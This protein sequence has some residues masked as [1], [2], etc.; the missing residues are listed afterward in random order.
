M[1]VAIRAV[2]PRVHIPGGAPSERGFDVRALATFFGLACAFSWAW[3]FPLVLSGDVVRQGRGWP[4]HFPSLVGPALAAFVVVAWTRG[5]PG[6]HGL[7]GSMGRY[8]V[9]LRWWLVALSPA[10]FL[11]AALL[12]IWIGRG[13]LPTVGDFG[14]FSGLPSGLGVVGVFAVI[15][16]VNGFGE[17]TGWRGYAIPELQRKFSPLAAA[18]ILAPIWALW[19]VPQF[20]LLRSYSN[21]SGSELVGFVF[22]LTAG[23]VVLTW[24]VN[25]TASV[26]LVVVWHG[27]YNLVGGSVAATGGGATIAAVVSTMIM[28]QA[29]VLVVF[30]I[31]ARRAGRPGIMSPT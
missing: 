7:L 13:T 3:V 28:V 10:A 14:R 11:G 9:G 1:K 30:E 12:G 17:E 22:G 15:T 26:L 24:L 6:V 27:T 2:S 31:R 20:F 29:G 21:F 18:V 8:R 23:S 25:R 19:H 5:R 16:I 4:T